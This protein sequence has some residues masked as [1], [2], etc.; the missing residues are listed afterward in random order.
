MMS[1]ICS[2]AQTS[3]LHRCA[4]RNDTLGGRKLVDDLTQGSRL[5]V[6]H[7]TDRNLSTQELS[8]L[9]AATAEG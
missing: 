5:F 2:P 1:N 3:L 7:L 4:A 6:F 8:T 9:R